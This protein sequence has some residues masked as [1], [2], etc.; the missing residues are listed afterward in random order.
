MRTLKSVNKGIASGTFI[1]IKLL[2]IAKISL[3]AKTMRAATAKKTLQ[4]LAIA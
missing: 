2:W 4:I 3:K 1:K